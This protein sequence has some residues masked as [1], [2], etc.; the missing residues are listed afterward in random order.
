MLFLNF[1]DRDAAAHCR[2]SIAPKYFAERKAYFPLQRIS[3]S[4]KKVCKKMLNKSGPKT[5][6]P[7]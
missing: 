5:E 6:T 4:I 2:D 3:L 7:I 1:L